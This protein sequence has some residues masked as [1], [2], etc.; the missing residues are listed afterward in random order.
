MLFPLLRILLLLYPLLV[1]G[2]AASIPQTWTARLAFEALSNV[3][4]K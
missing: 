4:I 1:L 2:Q 3:L